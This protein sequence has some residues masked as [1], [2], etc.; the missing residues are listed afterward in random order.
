[1]YSIFLSTFCSY[2]SAHL[3]R[4]NLLFP[5]SQERHK[6]KWKLNNNIPFLIYCL[7]SIC[8]SPFCLSLLRSLYRITYPFLTPCIFFFISCYFICNAYF[9]AFFSSQNLPPNFWSLYPSISF[10][11][12][13]AIQTC[14]HT[15][16]LPSLLPKYCCPST[17]IW[18]PSPL[19]LPHLHPALLPVWIQTSFLRRAMSAEQVTPLVSRP[20]HLPCLSWSYVAQTRQ[21][22]RGRS[23]QKLISLLTD[24]HSWSYLAPASF[25]IQ[26]KWK[27]QPVT[28]DHH[29]GSFMNSNWEGIFRKQE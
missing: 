16:T 21:V 19:L 1:M 3:F 5:A 13:S 18:P 28:A 7:H 9:F 27:E 8:S 23:S 29:G 17:T 4:Y 25:Q 20:E 15:H 2:H 11:L 10:S 22:K 24:P 14:T 12:Q 26:N 6:Y